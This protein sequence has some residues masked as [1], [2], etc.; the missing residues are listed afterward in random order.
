MKFGD[1]LDQFDKLPVIKSIGSTEQQL[2]ES[3][4]ESDSEIKFEVFPRAS[5]PPP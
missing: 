5:A 4:A 1:L 3:K 2:S